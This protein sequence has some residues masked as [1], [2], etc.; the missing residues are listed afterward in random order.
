MILTFEK[1]IDVCRQPDTALL[2]YLDSLLVQQGSRACYTTR[3]QGHYKKA[4][5][6]IKKAVPITSNRPSDKVKQLVLPFKV[7]YLVHQSIL[8]TKV[9]Q[10]VLLHQL[11][12]FLI[13]SLATGSERTYLRP[14]ENVSEPPRERFAGSG[15]GRGTLS[16]PFR[17]NVGLILLRNSV[18]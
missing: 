8:L 11:I 15:E 14:R 1:S 4:V 2:K 6:R 18:A 13:T 16:L 9:K 7:I 3:L 5:V 17:I 12:Y 10:L